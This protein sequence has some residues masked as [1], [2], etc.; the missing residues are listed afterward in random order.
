MTKHTAKRQQRSG[1]VFFVPFDKGDGQSQSSYLTVTGFAGHSSADPFTAGVKSLIHPFYYRTLEHY[2]YKNKIKIIIFWFC[3]SN[4]SSLS[5]SDFSS[6]LLR[7]LDSCKGK[8]RKNTF[9]EKKEN[10]TQKKNLIWN[11]RK[12]PLLRSLRS[13]RRGIA[14][15]SVERVFTTA[16]SVVQ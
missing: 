7:V 10:I 15:A 14:T 3:I 16:F 1:F 2:S 4:F 9:E 13:S 11:T 8:K 12:S 6:S 5:F